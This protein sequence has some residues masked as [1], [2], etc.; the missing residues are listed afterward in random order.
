M[1]DELKEISTNL[2]DI[3]ELQNQSRN[4]VANK[5][6]LQETILYFS[7]VASPANYRKIMDSTE[8]NC[9]SSLITNIFGHI[10]ISLDGRTIE[11]IPALTAE[12]KDEVILKT[13]IKNFL[14]RMQIS[15]EGCIYPALQ[16]IWQEHMVP[17]EFLIELCKYSK[18]VP[19]KREILTANALFYG[20]EGDF[21]TSIHLLA[22]QVENMIRQI[23]KH[24][25]I[26]TTHTD[27]DGIEHEN[28][29]SS[30][31]SHEKARE[32]LGDD[33][34]FELQAVFTSSLSTN[35]RNEV[36]HG[37]LDDETSN[38][39]YSIYAWWMI[40]RLIIQNI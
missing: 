28:G 39:R 9:Q 10:S 16:Q 3:S 22:P 37:L 7:G 40:L 6:T 11:K 2:I 25:E 29:L 17:R 4:H 8:E 5:S 20:F 15:V 18:F 36:S 23:L 30:L 32:I 24:K 12:N 27:P 26:I 13:A 34:W 14:I 21:R 35:F 33:L 1:T 31:L 38:S 19:D